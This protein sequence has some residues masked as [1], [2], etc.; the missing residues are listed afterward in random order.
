MIDN[1][2]HS[3]DNTKRK[4]RKNNG[5]FNFFHQTRVHA[6]ARRNPITDSEEWIAD[7]KVKNNKAQRKNPSRALRSH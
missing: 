5:T 1:K 2:L 4:E 3:S 6:S 7:N